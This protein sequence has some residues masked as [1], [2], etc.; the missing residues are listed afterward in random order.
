MQIP[1]N[2]QS[3]DLRNIYIELK[4]D[5]LKKRMIYEKELNDIHN[6]ETQFK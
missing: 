6:L 4:S 5:I 2:F 3:D 1:Y